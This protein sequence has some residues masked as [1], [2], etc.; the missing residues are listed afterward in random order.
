MPIAAF[1]LY[2][3]HR[4][5]EEIQRTGVI[6]RSSHPFV[7]WLTPECYD[8]PQEAADRLALPS[9]PD[10]RVGPIPPNRLGATSGLYTVSPSLGK[11]GGGTELTTTVPFPVHLAYNFSS[12]TYQYLQNGA[13][14]R[15]VSSEAQLA[16]QVLM[17]LTEFLERAVKL[18]ERCED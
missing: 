14:I 3:T 1:Y 17:E 6:V 5:L 7:T 12:K 8:D 9:I 2:V 16:W 15:I 18:A 4:R 11:P 10:Y 13:D